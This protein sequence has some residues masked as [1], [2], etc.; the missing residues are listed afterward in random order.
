MGLGGIVVLHKGF[1]ILHSYPATGLTDGRRRMSEKRKNT[2]MNRVFA[3]PA[4]GKV[5]VMPFGEY[6]GRLT[7]G[8]KIVQVFDRQAAINIAASLESEKA[9]AGNNWPGVLVDLEHR[10]LDADGD[11]TAAAWL[12]SVESRPDGLYGELQLTTLGKPL[13][14]GGQYRTLSPVF[15][16]EYIGGSQDKLPRMRPVE[17]QSIGLTNKP[18]LKGMIPLSIPEGCS[19]NSEAW[20][21]EEKPETGNLKP[22]TGSGFNN[23]AGEAGTRKERSMTEILKALGL[24]E[25]S[26]EA[27]I[28]DAIGKLQAAAASG[29]TKEAELVV[30]QNKLAD[31][32]R[33]ALLSQV[34]KD[35]ADLGD[36]VVNK[37]DLKALLVA[38]R[39]TALKAIA[40]VRPAAAEAK[41]VAANKAYMKDPEL[42]ATVQKRTEREAAVE[43]LMAKNRGMTRSQAWSHLT[44]S[45]PDMFK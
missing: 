31:L 2:I 9:K 16:M 6:D 7:D 43:K 26:G 3:E 28:L 12:T 37:D 44:V 24:A 1:V 29:K 11:T 39:D 4:D 27:A 45:Q 30:A 35:L 38:N 20:F 22:E 41:P 13:V 25:G 17:L 42:S 40:L 32:E 36:R 34:E 23:K 15:A 21:S 10:S 18:N 19:V 14:E 33:A 8:T 5:Q